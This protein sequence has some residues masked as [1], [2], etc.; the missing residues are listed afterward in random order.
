MKQ[1]ARAAIITSFKHLAGKKPLD[2]ITVK[3][4]CEHCNVNRQT[5]YNHFTDIMDIFKSIFYDEITKEIAQN[6]T[7]E[8]WNGGFLATMRYLKR[9][10]KM[11]M[12]VYYSS[13]RSE[14]FNFFTNISNELLDGVVGECAEK[15]G[16]K[17]RDKDRNFIVDFYRYIFNGLMMDWMVEG[18]G[19]EPEI[20]LKKLLLMIS[21]SIP[22]AVAAFIREDTEVF[23]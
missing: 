8:T 14:A 2:K 5:F 3:A 9:N 22:R 15:I 19:E 17:L 10:S 1:N 18:M 23:K 7:F 12:N 13:Y 21:G 20:I 16:A 4:I 11:I 6:R